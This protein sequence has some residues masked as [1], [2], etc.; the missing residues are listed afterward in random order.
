MN[1]GLLTGVFGRRTLEE[2]ME[3]IVELAEET[4]INCLEVSLYGRPLSKPVDPSLWPWEIDGN[5]ELKGRLQGFLEPFKIKGAHLPFAN[6]TS[7]SSN[8]RLQKESRYQVKLGMEKSSELG[9]DYVVVHLSGETG[10]LPEDQSWLL[11]KEAVLDYLDYAEDLGICLTL[12]NTDFIHNLDKQA[13]MIRE[14]NSPRLKATLD[15]G[16]AHIPRE[17]KLPYNGY[18][19]VARYIESERGILAN[20]H[21]HDYNDK[22]HLPIGNGKINFSS[23]IRSLE[24]INFQGSINM[25]FNAE[26]IQTVVRSLSKLKSF[27]R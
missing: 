10:G 11:F 15:T 5:K 13:R 18:G 25:E 3:L 8:P 24:K 4:Q 20:I 6:L 14:V 26:D 1:Y 9:L 22:D 23:I 27:E 19:S 16:H 21:A 17:E 2:A 12:E 7:V